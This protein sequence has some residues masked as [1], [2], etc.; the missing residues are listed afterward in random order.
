MPHRSIVCIAPVRLRFAT[1]SLWMSEVMAFTMASASA[2][3]S[4]ITLICSKSC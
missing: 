4:R 1:S 2:A 3:F